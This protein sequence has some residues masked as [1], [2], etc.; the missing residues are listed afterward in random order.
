MI[1][2]DI[3]PSNIIFVG[4]VAKVADIGLV[5]EASE[6]QSYVGTEG[7]IPPEGPN[8]PQADVFG[9]GKVLYE[10]A[11]AKDRLDFPEPATA[12]EDLPDRDLLVEL[13]T[14]LLK[15]C[16]PDRER[17]Y[18]SAAEMHAEL[19]MLQRG[20]SIVAQRSTQRRLRWIVTAGA[21]LGLVTVL[22]LGL[23]RVLEWRT[24][25]MQGTS[26]TIHPRLTGKILPRSARLPEHCL[27]LSSAYT[28]PL[29][30]QWYP[31]PAE[32][33][34]AALPAGMQTLAGTPFDVRGIVQLAG[35]EIS[36]YGA[37]S[38][39]RRSQ[40]IRVE[41][42]AERLHF[43]HGALSE[44]STGQVIGRYRIDYST[45]RSVEVPIVFGGNLRALWQPKNGD[46][47]V[48]NAVLAWRGQNPATQPRDLELR[49]YKFTWEN[50]WPAEEIVAVEFS[51]A[52]G[53]AAPLLVALT[54]DDAALSS[55][56]KTPSVDLVGA[57]QKAAPSFPAV[58]VQVGSQTLVDNPVR[59][60]ANSV[61]IGGRFY[62]GFRFKTPEKQAMDLIWT[63]SPR[64]S[65]YQGW[66]IL[67]MTGGLKLG[68]EDWL[69]ATPAQRK[70]GTGQ[71]SDFVVQFLSGR[72]LQP[73]REYFIWFG[74]DTNRSIELQA[75][76]KF[77]PSGSVDPY[78]SADLLRAL[79]LSI[80]EEHSFHR[81]Y[82]L[83]AIR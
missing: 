3:K 9:L 32:N 48:P 73:G 5:S 12:L 56:Q 31:G 72:K 21:C 35:G 81:H 51:S 45:T 30:E 52:G 63:F 25:A 17:R 44:V 33:T 37:D 41:R 50:P 61:S 2:R 57:I 10:L 62:D 27:D 69:H 20:E 70:N 82:C 19:Q 83:G 54:A 79:G 80:T 49:L 34:L 23:D 4:G 13:N 18:A 14:I 74:S 53:N 66:F 58:P 60:F 47:A 24:Q 8:S 65:G 68:F 29:T 71:S 7:F 67:P 6:S 11:M 42:W 76:L 1:H 22:A 55:E 75:G 26:S 40:A 36:S 16:Q 77:L 39:P 46:G 64:G 28:A 43:L 38:Y 78:N 15:A 59:L